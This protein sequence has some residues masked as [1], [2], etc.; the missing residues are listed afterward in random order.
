MDP[1]LT[2]DT[3]FG[4]PMLA[5]NDGRDLLQEVCPHYKVGNKF[6]DILNAIPAF[7]ALVLD[8]D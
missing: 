6:I 1:Q 7:I 2:V 4:H 3:N 8:M 5:L